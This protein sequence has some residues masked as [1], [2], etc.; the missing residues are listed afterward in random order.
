MSV[1]LSLSPWKQAAHFVRNMNVTVKNPTNKSTSKYFSVNSCLNT[2]PWLVQTSQTSL[3]TR[4]AALLLL[5]FCLLMSRYFFVRT[6]YKNVRLTAESSTDPPLMH[7]KEN[8]R[9]YIGIFKTNTF[10]NTLQSLHRRHTLLL[11][12]QVLLLL[13]LLLLLVAELKTSP[14]FFCSLIKEYKNV[15]FPLK[16]RVVY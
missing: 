12:T 14:P 1:F 3:K 6:W 9:N 11:H 2:G 8:R 7:H 5:H 16:C 15:L 10:L 13:L 4:H